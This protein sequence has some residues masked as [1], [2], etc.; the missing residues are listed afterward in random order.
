MECFRRSHVHCSMAAKPSLPRNPRQDHKIEKVGR[1][2]CTELDVGSGR[3]AGCD[4]FARGVCTSLDSRIC[5]CPPFAQ[6]VAPHGA[7]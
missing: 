2:L 6:D 7:R 4:A 1:R 3:D 5:H